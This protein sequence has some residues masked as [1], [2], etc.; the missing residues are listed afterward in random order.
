MAA[1]QVLLWVLGN[2]GVILSQLFRGFAN[3]LK[4]MEVFNTRDLANAFKLAADTA[5]KAVMKPTEGDFNCCKGCAIMQWILPKM[6]DIVLFMENYRP[7]KRS[8]KSNSRNV[9]SIETSRSSR[10]WWKG[11]NVCFSWCT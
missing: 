7:W 1:V 2:S 11:F 10:C 8:I 5:Y 6:K 4:D 9:T 3:G